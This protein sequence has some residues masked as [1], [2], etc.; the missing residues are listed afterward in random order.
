[1]KKK[2]FPPRHINDPWAP[3]DGLFAGYCVFCG[4]S[5]GGPYSEDLFHTEC[6]AKEESYAKNVFARAGAIYN[7]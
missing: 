4:G 1:M 2:P 7:G 5:L 6:D 3:R